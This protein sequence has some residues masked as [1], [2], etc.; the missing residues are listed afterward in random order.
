MSKIVPEVIC[1]LERMSVSPAL[2]NS[3]GREIG[4]CILIPIRMA[5][6]V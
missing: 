6:R 5:L 3:T 1:F 2:T 4:K